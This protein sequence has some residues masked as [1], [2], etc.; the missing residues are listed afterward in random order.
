MESRT[1]FQVKKVEFQVLEN[2]EI[3]DR[4]KGGILFVE[5]DRNELIVRFADMNVKLLF[6]A[7][8]TMLQQLKMFDLEDEFRDWV[9]HIQ[10]K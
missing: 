6:G 10:S 1:E 5:G 9:K 2:G 7:V 8:Y 4:Y 3:T